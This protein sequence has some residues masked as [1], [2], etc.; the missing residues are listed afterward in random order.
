MG[1]VFASRLKLVL[2]LVLAQALAG[3]AV[4]LAQRFKQFASL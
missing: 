1:A 4:R 3:N 2:K